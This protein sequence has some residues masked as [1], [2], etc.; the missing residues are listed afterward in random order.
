MANDPRAQPPGKYRVLADAAE[1]S[2]NL[3][4]P[5]YSNAATEELVKASLISEMFAAAARGEMAPEEAVR[6]AEAKIKPIFEKWRQQ[7]K[8]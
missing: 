8:I 1:W 2:T 4:H 5:G 3:G 6:T 7:G